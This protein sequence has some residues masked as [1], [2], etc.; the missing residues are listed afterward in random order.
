MTADTKAKEI[1]EFMAKNC[2][3]AEWSLVRMKKKNGKKTNFVATGHD[4]VA[5]RGGKHVIQTLTETTVYS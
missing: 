3:D 2:N 1:F 4:E 5:E